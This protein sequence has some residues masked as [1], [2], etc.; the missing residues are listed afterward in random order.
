MA[1]FRDSAGREWNVTL[2][3]GTAKLVKK[4]H[5]FDFL[6]DGKEHPIL[7]LAGDM[8]LLGNVLWTLCERQARERNITEQDFGE[9]IAGDSL[10]AAVNALAEAY[11]DFS[12][13]PKRRET[14]KRLWARLRDLEALELEKAQ[15]ALT[16]ST[17]GSASTN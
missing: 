3:L 15:A 6:G 2:N 1:I 12:P 11:S 14:L 16:D 5:G 17:P 7:R 4:A 8:E 13:N 10:D 9:A